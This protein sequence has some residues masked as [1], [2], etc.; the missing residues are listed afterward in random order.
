MEVSHGCRL[1]NLHLPDESNRGFNM[2]KRVTMHQA[3]PKLPVFKNGKHNML[4]K[5]F[6]NHRN[7]VC[8]V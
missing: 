3:E 1:L 5:R 6:K 7:G 2:Y 4:Q 8:S